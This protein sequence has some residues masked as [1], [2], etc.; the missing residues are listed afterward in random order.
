MWLALADASWSEEYGLA[1]VFLFLLVA[2]V[3]SAFW[4]FKKKDEEKDKR[5]KELEG[6]V[7]D[8]NKQHVD[9]LK[10]TWTTC[11]DVVHHLSQFSSIVEKSDIPGKSRMIEEIDRNVRKTKE[12]AEEIKKALP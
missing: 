4:W 12:T 8:L 10:G 11:Q 7:R 3:S 1:G 6:E 2:I 5:I 9:L